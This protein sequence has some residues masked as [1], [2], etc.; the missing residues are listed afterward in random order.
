M[1]NSFIKLPDRVEAIL[2]RLE[3]AGY[4]AYVVGG[5][6]RDLIRNIPPQDYD[7]TTSATP[8]QVMD[9][10]REESVLPTGVQHGTVT[11]VI[12][13]RAYEITTF[14]GEG[15]Y[16][17]HRRPDTVQFIDSVEADLARRDFTVGA[18]AY[19]PKRGV[20]D[21]FGGVRDVK[22]GI[23]RAVG[24]PMTRFREDGLRVLRAIRFASVCGFTIEEK[25]AKALHEGKHLVRGVSA[26]R[27]YAELTK[28]LCGERV[29]ETLVEFGDVIA[30]IIPEISKLF[31][32]PQNTPYHDRDVWRHT[33]AALRAIRPDPILRWTMLLHDIA[34]P[35]C[36]YVDAKGVAHFKT[37]PEK[38][39]P[40]AGEILTRLRADRGTKDEVT[41]LIALHD[42]DL[43]CE[44]GGI[45]RLLIELGKDR[46]QRL[47]W[48]KEADL[49][50]KSSYGQTHGR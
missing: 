8:R 38:G 30:E 49:A 46:M 27:Q 39:A 33:L 42:V 9:V 7:I 6:V 28:T 1:I 32:F 21:P 3:Q 47:L 40:I 5:A 12:D 26:E 19:S 34:K 23:I 35:D 11:L 41:T 43:P 4:A 31:D 16:T 14:R 17:D 2:Y 36:H 48:V 20:C 37:H 24:D 10:F 22:R 44:R 29:E 45:Y 25:T 13:E 15:T 18:I 50:G